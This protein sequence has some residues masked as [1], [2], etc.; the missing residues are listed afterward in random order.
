MLV[1][2]GDYTAVVL[3]MRL[4]TE[5]PFHRKFSSIKISFYSKALVLCIGLDIAALYPSWILLSGN[6]NI[7]EMV[8]NNNEIK[9]KLLPSI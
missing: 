6:R 7:L 2:K 3:P 4:K 1:V 8:V 9:I 5:V